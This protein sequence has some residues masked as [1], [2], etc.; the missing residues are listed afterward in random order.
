MVISKSINQTNVDQDQQC[1]MAMLGHQFFYYEQ[2]F[3]EINN[4]YLQIKISFVHSVF[5]RI[6]ILITH[7]K[8]IWC[9]LSIWYDF[10]LLQTNHGRI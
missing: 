7:D 8:V 9:I 1:L 3:S 4:F 5:I 10:Y 6:N 2:T